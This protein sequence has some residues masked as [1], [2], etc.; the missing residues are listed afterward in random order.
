[1]LC[2]IL[3]HVSSLPLLCSPR[4]LRTPLRGVSSSIIL[5]GSR[6]R[7]EVQRNSRAQGVVRICIT[8]SCYTPQHKPPRNRR[9]ISV[10]HRLG[11]IDAV[12][13]LQALPPGVPGTGATSRY[14]EYVVTHVNLTDRIHLVVSAFDCRSSV[15]SERSRADRANFYLGTATWATSTRRTFVTNATTKGL[16][17]ESTSEKT[18][19]HRLLT[20]FVS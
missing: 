3:D 1:M 10:K 9:D 2:R 7:A 13:C 20:H 18:E 19:L 16:C 5:R 15:T 6:D 12:K 4:R 17:R 8:P 14:E 11:Y